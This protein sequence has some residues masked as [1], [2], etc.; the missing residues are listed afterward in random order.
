MV[1]YEPD[2]KPLQLS[3]YFGLQGIGAVAWLILLS[4]CTYFAWQDEKMRPYLRLLFAWIAFNVFFYNIWGRELILWAPAWSWA[5]MT[6]VLLGAP[7]VSWKFI[8]AL[9]IPIVVSQIYT[10]GAI[11]SALLTIIQ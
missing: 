1:S 10:L 2:L 4:T 3:Y 11:K 9:F 7:R 6:L 8:A 5:L